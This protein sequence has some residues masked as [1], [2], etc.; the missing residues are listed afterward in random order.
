VAESPESEVL[1]LRARVAEL[2]QRLGLLAGAEEQILGAR[3]QAQALLDNIPH[4]AWM[5]NTRGVFLAVNEAFARAC[6]H[7]KEHVLGKTDRDIWPLEHADKYAQDDLRVIATGQQFFVEERIAEGGDFKWFET[8]KTPIRDRKQMV[9]GTV[10]LARDITDRKRA[11]AEHQLLERHLQETQKLES[12]GVLAGG[13]AH[14]FNNLLVAVL[15]NAD[16]ALHMLARA[17]PISA[18]VERITDV[19][20]AALHAAE[21]TNQMLAYSGRGHFEVRPISLTDLVLDMGHLLA[22]SL[23]KKATVNYDLRDLPAVQADV[24]QMRQVIMNL[25]TNASDALGDGAGTIHVRTGI[26]RVGASLADLYGHVPLVS[27][28]YAFLEVQ[29]DGC[30]MDAEV[31]ARLFEPFF[32]TKFTGR[33]LGLSAVQGIVRGHGGG[34]VLRS[35]PGAGTTIKVL[36]RCDDQIAVSARSA[37]VAEPS[38]WAGH[39][40]A[41]LVDDDARVRIVTTLLLRDLGFEVIEVASGRDAI[42]EFARRA[43]EVRFVMLDVTMPDLSGDRVL[44]ELRKLRPNIPVLLCSGYSE[45]EMRSRFDRKDMENFLQKPYLLSALKTHL[46]RLLR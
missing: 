26:E 13:I 21:L 16:L 30:G 17:E 9:V 44:G 36:L 43:A 2:E 10:G 41:L 11:E 25:I 46:R 45:E 40:I 7:S 3:A 28:S 32:T 29:D 4:M 14:D 24:A 33:G 5:K 19:R 15:A 27:G 1:T 18:I 34:I 12:L 35:A 20:N 42:V 31:R 22:A 6:G 8:F 38:V 39:G 37:P 23:S